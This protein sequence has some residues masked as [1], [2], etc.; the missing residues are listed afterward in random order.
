MSVRQLG[1]IERHIDAWVGEEAFE[2]LYSETKTLRYEKRCPTIPKKCGVL[3]AEHSKINSKQMSKPRV[4]VS[5]LGMVGPE[6]VD[7]QL[8][9]KFY[10]ERQ[11]VSVILSGSRKGC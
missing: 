7:L 10:G 1:K 5:V 8:G 9:Y 3:C 2:F 11:R 4:L 6:V